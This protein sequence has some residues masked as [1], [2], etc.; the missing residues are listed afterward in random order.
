MD[1]TC[2]LIFIFILILLY[3]LH[4]KKESYINVTIPN[5][6]LKYFSQSEFLKNTKDFEIT[7]LKYKNDSLNVDKYIDSTVDIFMKNTLNSN[8]TRYQIK[9]TFNKNEL[10]QYF[11]NNAYLPIVNLLN[12]NKIDVSPGYIR[13][14]KDK[15][16]FNYHYDCLNLL[17]IQLYG[18]RIIYTKNTKKG[19]SK[20]HILNA[21]DILYIPMNQYHKVKTIGDLNINFNINLGETDINKIEKCKKNFK[22]D[23][24]IQQQRCKTNN[25]I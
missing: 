20:K 16:T 18:T 4:N 25:C 13:I 10:S 23:Y 3:I 9:Q 7:Y 17:L 15:W 2:I 5:N 22:K 6:I 14:S 11:Y 12:L 21:G 1:T 19:K 24:K 8:K